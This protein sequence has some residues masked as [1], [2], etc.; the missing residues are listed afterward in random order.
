M[1]VVIY[2]KS[3]E[4]EQVRKIDEKIMLTKIFRVIRSEEN[5]H[6]CETYRFSSKILFIEINTQTINS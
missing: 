1:L 3:I 4:N 6:A 2:S 5:G